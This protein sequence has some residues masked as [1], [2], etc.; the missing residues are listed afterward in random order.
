[1]IPKKDLERLYNRDGKSMKE[2]AHVLGYSQSKVCYWMNAHGLKRKSISEAVYI[3]S[4][5]NGD[6]FLL[7]MPI[8][9]E[10][11]KLFGIGIGLYWGEGT[12]ASKSSVRLGNTDP[13]LILVFVLFL[14]TFF[15]IQ[16]RDLRFGLQV[17]SD[18]NSE[19]AMDFWIKKIKVHREQFYKTIIT[20]ARSIGNY[21][22]KTQYGVMTVYYNNTKMKNLLMELLEKEKYG[23]KKSVG[24]K[25]L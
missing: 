8:N 3:K 4:N 23:T 10:E 21:R 17:F 5:P 25:P 13:D 16:K 14:T 18:M 11:A 6:P 20:P 2:I 12:K 7:R 24:Y 1:M 22:I 15:G 19:E 9:K